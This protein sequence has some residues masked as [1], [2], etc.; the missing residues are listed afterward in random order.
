VTSNEEWKLPASAD[1]CGRCQQ[2]LQPGSLVTTVVRLLPTGP[3]RSDLCAS[4][5]EGVEAEGSA[6][7]WRRKRP[8]DAGKK[9]VVDYAM[10]RE[11]FGRMLERP[12]EIYRRLSYLVALVLI[13]KRH[14]KLSGFEVRQGR[15]VM[16]VSRGAGQPALDVPAPHLSPEDMVSVREHLTRLLNADLQDHDL[17]ELS[18]LS[19]APSSEAA[20]T[21]APGDSARS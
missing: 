2:P 5:G 16:V 6:L 15:E 12:D 11:L 3:E 14:L 4:C 9:R 17:P 7:Y 13:R 18:E 20:P 21:P 10:L 1:A 8:A 19:A